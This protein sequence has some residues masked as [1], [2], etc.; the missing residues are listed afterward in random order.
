[1][2]DAAA[3]TPSVA[4]ALKIFESCLTR[5]LQLAGL[6]KSSLVVALVYASAL[7]LR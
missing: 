5:A 4:K 3:N 1:M 6:P 7:E 2:T